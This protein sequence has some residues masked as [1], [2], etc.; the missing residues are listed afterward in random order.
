MPWPWFAGQ[1][2]TAD[3]L[4]RSRMRQVVQSANQE[5]ESS[6]TLVPTEIS[7]PVEAGATYWV[8]TFIAYSAASTQEETQGGGFRWNWSVP[9][10]TAMP[11]S[12]VAYSLEDPDNDTDLN[13]GGNVILRSPAASTEMRAEGTHPDNFNSVQETA[14]L[15]AGGASGNATLQFAQWA[16]G[17]TATVLRGILRARSLYVRVQ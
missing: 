13:T 7:I 1:A 11:R 14:I 15:Q 4:N 12:T 17:S 16:S 8:Q 9:S 2:I 10:G 3:D 5:V 6:T